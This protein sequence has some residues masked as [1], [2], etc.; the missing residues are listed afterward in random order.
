MYQ[1]LPP[2]CAPQGRTYDSEGKTWRKNVVSE[3]ERRRYIEHFYEDV[4]RK[5]V[6]TATPNLPQTAHK[7]HVPNPISRPKLHLIS[8]SSSRF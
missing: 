3:S 4:R 7:K 5:K 8:T 1:A 2:A 6:E